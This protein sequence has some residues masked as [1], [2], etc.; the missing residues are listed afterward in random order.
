MLR[1]LRRGADMTLAQAAEALECAE[2]KMSRIEAAHSGIRSLDLRVLLDA[3]GIDDQGLRARLSELARH[4]R[5]RGWWSQYEGALR[6]AYADYIALEWDAS[7]IYVVETALVPGLLQTP[8]YA[9]AVV[10]MQA[11]DQTDDEVQAQVKVRGQRRQVF[12]RSA[13]LRLWVILTESTLNHR[14]GGAEIMRE[15]WENLIPL[16]QQTNVQVQV[17]PAES[18]L[19]A[20]LHGPFG[21]LAFP[22]PAETDVV[23]ADNLLSTIYY[24]EPE[25]VAFYTTLYRRLNSEALSADESLARIRRAVEEMEETP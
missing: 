19:N 23:Y 3:Y 11:P 17:L 5:E 8:A 10:R 25:Q 20:A 9:E 14:V 18:P 24:E 16:A 4:G 6:P 15:Q 1:D 2:S 12:A 13:P 7:D 21:I 22:E